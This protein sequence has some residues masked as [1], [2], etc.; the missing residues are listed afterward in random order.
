MSSEAQQSSH[1]H[2]AT[3]GPARSWRSKIVIALIGFLLIVGF[4]L[5]SEHR[6]HVLGYLPYLLVL[7]CPLLHMLHHGHG[8]HGAHTHASERGEQ[9]LKRRLNIA[10]TIAREIASP[11][12]AIQVQAV[13]R[14]RVG[15]GANPI[16]EVPVE[17][18]KGESIRSRAAVAPLPR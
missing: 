3:Q 16:G 14:R 8:R 6:V 5:L 2:G 17:P 15:G 4:L 9:T 11:G 18:P 13:S 7:A 1:H 12:S 10:A